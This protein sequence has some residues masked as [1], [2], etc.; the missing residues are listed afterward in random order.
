MSATVRSYTDPRRLL[1]YALNNP[2]RAVLIAAVVVVVAVVSLVALTVPAVP[3][4]IAGYAFGLGLLGFAYPAYRRVQLVRAATSTSA[5]S[6]A[7]GPA[8]VHGTV[9]PAT[10]DL[11]EAPHSGTECVAYRTVRK[12][13]HGQETTR[14]FESETVPFYVADDTGR[15]LVDPTSGTL[16]LTHDEGARLLSLSGSGTEESY[17]EPGD[18]VTVYGEVVRPGVQYDG[19][20]DAGS[21]HDD[22]AVTDGPRE[23]LPEDGQA[24]ATVPGEI[25]FGFDAG[26]IPPGAVP[27]DVDVPPEKLPEGV[28]SVEEF[29]SGEEMTASMA[30]VPPQYRAYVQRMMDQSSFPVTTGDSGDRSAWGAG[31]RDADAGRGGGG[32]GAGGLGSTVRGMAEAAADFP[33]RYDH[34]LADEAYVLGRGPAHEAV[35]VTDKRGTRVYGRQVLVALAVVGVSLAVIGG[36]A[37][38]MLGLY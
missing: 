31:G 38:S 21:E 37:A 29:A 16:D 5:D 33:G 10:D 17:L 24:S 27:D 36:S 18:T 25:S 30:D 3:T 23:S 9:R 35:L 1:R 14:D 15:T 19:R 11:L 28:D 22:Q 26:D 32:T 8:S 20:P 13:R 2:L 7:P 12:R 4:W 6:L 34:L